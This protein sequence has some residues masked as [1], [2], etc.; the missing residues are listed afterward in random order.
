MNRVTISHAGSFTASLQHR[1][2]H[3][4]FQEG[5]TNKVPVIITVAK[6]QSVQ[7]ATLRWIS[8][9]G[10]AYMYGSG[11]NANISLPKQA[12]KYLTMGMQFPGLK[13]EWK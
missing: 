5:E 10:L 6:Y 8:K 2:K 4:P 3:S 1:H 9:L 11:D 7:R 12:F 13:S